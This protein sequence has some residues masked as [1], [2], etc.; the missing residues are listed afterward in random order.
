MISRRTSLA[1]AAAALVGAGTWWL[2]APPAPARKPVI[3]YLSAYGEGSMPIARRFRQG[4][5][6][7]GFVEGRNVEIEYRY[8][9]GRTDRLPALARDL[10]SSGVDVMATELVPPDVVASIARTS[11]VPTVF[12]ASGDIV[13]TGLPESYIPL[14]G[15]TTGLVLAPESLA[16]RRLELLADLMP[17]YAVIGFLVHPSGHADA[18]AVLR[19]AA[20]ALGREIVVVSAGSEDELE[21]AFVTLARKGVGGLV[22]MFDAFFAEQSRRI[23]AQ[24][25]QYLILV[26]FPARRYVE[27]GGIISYGVDLKVF[28][29]QFGAYV[30]R[31]LQGTPSSELPILTPTKFE[32]AVN[33]NAARAAGFTVPRAFVARADAVIE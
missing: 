8:A 2:M 3:G 33:L 14:D 21:S 1:G 31:I 4:L 26:V 7:L 18:A 20:K 12:Y 16:A 15:R 28:Q 17:K 5:A 10:V 25:N 24:A 9:E 23:I 6:G 32:L 30:G 22:V 11:G 13:A 19:P 29:P 27:A